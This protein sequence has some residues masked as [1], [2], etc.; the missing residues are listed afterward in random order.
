MSSVLDFYFDFSSPYGYFA[1]MRIEALAQ[2]HGRSVNWHPVLLGAIFKTTGAIPLPMVPIK[3]SYA[4][5]D[6]ER[7]A[8]LHGIAFTRPEPFPIATQLAA[9]AMLWTKEQHGESKAVEFS[10]RAYLAYFAD[11]RDITQAGSISAIASA[12]DID[13]LALL[14]GAGSPAIKDA[15]KAEVD[16]AMARGVFGAPFMIVDEEP[17]WGFDRFAQLEVFLKDGKI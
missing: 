2:K 13:P 8:R 4:L 9:R 3:G 16:A 12:L 6:M 17:F 10:K 15:L 7:S 11:G 5:H 14:E 1:A